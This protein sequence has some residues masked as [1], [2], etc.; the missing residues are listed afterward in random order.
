M[1]TPARNIQLDNC[2][3]GHLVTLE[4]LAP[5]QILPLIITARGD[6]DLEAWYESN[7]GFL[8]QRLLE[9]GGILFRGFGKRDA[10]GLE[11][12]IQVSA[13]QSLAYKERSS[14]RTQVNGNIYTSTEYPPGQ[15]IFLHNENSYQQT[16][17][18]KLYFLCTLEPKD[19]GETPLADCRKIH[20]RLPEPLRGKFAEKGFRIVRNYGMAMGLDWQMVFG[21]SN[22][23]EVDAYCKQRDIRT[24]WKPGDEL[25][26]ITIRNHPSMK[27]PKTGAVT[28]FNHGT[29]FHVTTMDPNLGQVL[30]DCMAEEDLPT[31]TYYGDG[32]RIAPED[33]DALRDIYHKE[34][35]LFPWREGDVLII[36]NMLTA[37]GRRPFS[38]P[39]KILVG[40]ADPIDRETILKQT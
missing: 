16:W 34:T 35:V 11:S 28:W 25:R 8:E 4:T 7:A 31:N 2:T 39:R 13:G 12:F 23:A 33:L 3:D 24:E 38:G 17:P 18:M 9:N 20:A 22:K 14:P 10:A 26:T 5:D 29:F 21:T 36:D 19:R 6:V 40:M 27:H 30:M 32:T 15:N 37:H 1:I